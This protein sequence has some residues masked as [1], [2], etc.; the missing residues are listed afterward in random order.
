MKTLLFKPFDRFSETALITVGLIAAVIGSYLAHLFQVRFDGALDLHFSPDL[1]SLETAFIENGINI[2]C[3]T[4][5]S[6]IAG[7][8]IN[9][10]VRLVDLLAV[11]LIA[12][13]PF[14]LVSLMNSSNALSAASNE[15]L[16]AVRAE[17]LESIS[18]SSMMLLGVLALVSILVLVWYIAL[19]WRGFKVATNAK[20]S[21][22]IIYFIGALLVAEVV[23][24]LL[25][26][27]LL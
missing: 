15:V 13:I 24:K 21:T 2:A 17:S 27:Q 22:H 10:R 18:S 26:V 23:S 3:L 8:L 6:F 16:E 4:L 12:R 14:Y 9:K 20:G 5:F 25:I 19:L 1:V 11:S 7:K